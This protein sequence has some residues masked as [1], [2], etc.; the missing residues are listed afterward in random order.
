M[1]FMQ[2]PD[3]KRTGKDPLPLIKKRRWQMARE[4]QRARRREEKRSGVKLRSDRNKKE[5]ARKRRQEQKMLRMSLKQEEN[6][7]RQLVQASLTKQA[8]L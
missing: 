8:S 7:A 4:V 5:R 2:A 6:R 3:L 1:F